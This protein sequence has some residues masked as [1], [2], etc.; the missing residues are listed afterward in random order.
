M[1][2][3]PGG[4]GGEDGGGGDDAGL[5]ADGGGAEVFLGTLEIR[6]GHG[7]FLQGFVIGLALAGD[8]QLDHLF[9]IFQLRT[10]QGSLGLRLPVFVH[11]FEPMEERD[12]HHH[13][14]IEHSSVPGVLDAV[15]GV[16][17]GDHPIGSQGH[18]GK[19][20]RAGDLRLRVIEAG[21]QVQAAGFGTVGP[22]VVQ[23]LVPG[24]LR[25]RNDV[26]VLVGQFD[27]TVQGKADALAQQHLCEGK[28]VRGLGAEHLGLVD[29]DLDLEGV[30]FGHDAGPDR[31][32]HIGLEGVQ[33]VG[34]G[35]GE[36]LFPG[37]GDDLPVGLV[38]IQH[39]LRLFEVV[40]GLRQI[41]RQGSH[42]IGIH[43]LTTHEHRLLDTHHPQPDIVEVR[44]QGLVDVRAD[45]VHRLGD[46]RELQLPKGRRVHLLQHPED[47]LP[48]RAGHVFLREGGIRLDGRHQL[49]H[50]TGHGL[51]HGAGNLLLHGSGGAF[52][53]A[54]HDGTGTLEHRGLEFVDQGDV[55]VVIHV[56]ARGRNGREI[57]RQGDLP[58]ITGHLHL[59]AGLFEV[60]AGLQGH[61]PA[62][63]Q[64][65]ALLRRCGH[66]RQEP[67]CQ[68]G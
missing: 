39:D 16:R 38:H 21:S 8:L 13:A 11:V 5:E 45:G 48:H 36:T 4:L 10:V 44:M 63:V 34:V 66:E 53:H 58:V 29:L 62:I 42:L 43:D 64:G 24:A 32:V 17:I 54:L 50:R 9:C 3:E 33:E 59:R 14:G 2:G 51:G 60:L 52:H 19:A 28:P 15:E 40:T 47:G 18:L 7:Q 67:G 37:D 22:D 49:G 56:R 35:L 6:L 31:G 55:P 46:I 12:V 23:G 57:I 30:G 1:G 20:V 61:F 41:L 68:D 65:E 25:E 27:L 26:Q